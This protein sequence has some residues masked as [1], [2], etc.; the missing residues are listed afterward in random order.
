MTRGS[1][2]TETSTPE[3]LIPLRP[4][5]FQILLILN[6]EER[7]GY[8]LMQD[9]KE[10]TDGRRILGPGTLYRTLKEMQAQNLIERSTRRPAPDLDDERRRYYRLTKFGRLVAAAEAQRMA[11][12]VHVARAGDLLPRGRK[13]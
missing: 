2:T 4:V 10:R 1:L 12:L 13:S 8:G 3:S 7:H 11:A 6:E 9:V 5:V